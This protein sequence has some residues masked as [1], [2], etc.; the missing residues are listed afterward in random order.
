MPTVRDSSWSGDR[1]TAFAV[2]L[3]AT[4]QVALTRAGDDLLL[5]TTQTITDDDPHL[6]AHFPAFAIFPGVF[7]VESLR[8]AVSAAV[9]GAG[10]F[11]LTGVRS[12]RFLSALVPGDQMTLTARITITDGG[13]AADAQA[14]AR[15]GA[16][17][18]RVKVDFGRVSEDRPPS[19]ASVRALLPHAHPMRLVDRIVALER[20]A[21]ITAIKAVTATEPCYRHLSADAAADGYA[22][23]AT[24]MLESFG[25]AA[26]VLA[27][28]SAG[29]RACGAD[30]VIILAGIRDCQID[31]NAYPGDVMRHVARLGYAAGDTMIV[32]GETWIDDRRIAVIGSMI[33]AVR[34]AA[35][36]H[37]T[38]PSACR[39]NE[40]VSG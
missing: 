17:A 34:P 11:S 7:I 8:Q 26:A 12:I 5:Q 40:Q 28:Q 4:E 25:Q 3:I 14:M 32:D 39:I 27:L 18:A 13:V 23:P 20:G 15:D 24:L 6:R 10:A 2:P 31:G 35:S 9:P 19:H 22:Y 30:D 29:V 38:T 21:S 37:S 1:D 36:L 33:A 16:V